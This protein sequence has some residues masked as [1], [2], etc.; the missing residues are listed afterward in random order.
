MRIDWLTE[1]I[2]KP[3]CTATRCAVRCRVPDSDVSID[4]SGRSWTAAR[5]MRVADSSS[6]T[7]PSILASS[8][9]RVEEKATS[10]SNPPEQIDSTTSSYPTTM[11]APVRPRRIRSSPSRSAVPGAMARRMARPEALARNSD[12]RQP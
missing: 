8:R 11:R 12:M 1:M 7:A 10:S 9:S 6:T 4:A 2:G 3:V 5:R